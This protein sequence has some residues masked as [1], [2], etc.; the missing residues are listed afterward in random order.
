LRPQPFFLGIAYAGLGLGLSALFVRETH[1]HVR[2]EA[3]VHSG[4]AEERLSTAQVFKLT[5]LTE[6][7]LSSCSQAGLANNLNDGLAAALPTELRR[8]PTEE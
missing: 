6:P 3:S 5:T 8:R 2:H 1:A 4:S 7:A